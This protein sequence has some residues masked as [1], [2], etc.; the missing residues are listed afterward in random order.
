MTSPT[1]TAQKA[2][3]V[4]KNVNSTNPAVLHN[5]NQYLQIPLS[6]RFLES[7]WGSKGSNPLLTDILDCKDNKTALR[8]G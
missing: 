1:V 4:L 8:D 2:V 6:F 3:K 5:H 7:T